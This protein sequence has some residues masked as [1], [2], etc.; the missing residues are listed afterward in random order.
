LKTGFFFILGVSS[1]MLSSCGK[2]TLYEQNLKIENTSWD[3]KAPAVFEVDVK[4]TITGYDFF[5]N[6]RNSGSY[7][8]SNLYVFVVTRFPGGQVTRD[9]VE[10]IM[11]TPE[12]DWI[13]T[14]FGDLHDQSILFKRAVNF[15]QS[16]KYRFEL[17]Q[18]MRE[19]PLEGIS[20]VGLRIE[21]MSD[22]K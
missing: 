3:S 8:F 22:T 9:T 6:L 13:G 10:C 17:I 19:D 18:A 14:G 4:D 1:L 12:G 21:K 5:I 7:G 2:E 20:D 16:G 11:A 15:P